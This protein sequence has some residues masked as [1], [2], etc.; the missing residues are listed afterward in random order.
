MKLYLKIDEAIENI[1]VFNKD[2]IN[3]VTKIYRNTINKNQYSKYVIS[4]NRIYKHLFKLK[5]LIIYQDYD[6]A[7]F[8]MGQISLLKL[9]QR[10]KTKD[11]YKDFFL[12]PDQKCY[13]NSYKNKL[14][15]VLNDILKNMI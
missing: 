6:K 9:Y 2:L 12:S 15:Y 10:D 7:Y 13:Q 8:D 4:N 5:S 1:L 11:A 14:D 3:R